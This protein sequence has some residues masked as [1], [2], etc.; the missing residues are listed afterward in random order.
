MNKKLDIE[1][2][3]LKSAIGKYEALESI[4]NDNLKQSQKSILKKIYKN[5]QENEMLFRKLSS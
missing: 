5:F 2:Q 1:D 4:K 3:M